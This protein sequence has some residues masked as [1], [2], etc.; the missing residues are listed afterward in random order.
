MTLTSQNSTQNDK[1][2]AKSLAGKVFSLTFWQSEQL[3]IDNKIV[4]GK[5]YSAQKPKVIF[6]V[7]MLVDYNLCLLE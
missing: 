1:E 7:R 6:L 3:L 5:I 4:F 2:I